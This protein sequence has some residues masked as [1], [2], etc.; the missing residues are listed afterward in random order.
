MLRDLR[1]C[2]LW[3]PLT[4]MQELRDNSGDRIWEAQRSELYGFVLKRVRDEAAA[5]DIVH[6][7]LVKAYERR[8]TL[9]E[10]GKLRPW[11]FQI[12]RNA[13]IDH[14]RAQRPAEALPED[15]IVED[16]EDGESTE[17]ELARCL[18]PLLDGLPEPY[19]DAL[20]LAEVEGS[21]QREVASRLGL[22][23]SGA[24]SRVQRGRRLLRSALFSCCSV[25]MDRRGGVMSYESRGECGGCHDRCK[26]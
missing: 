9:K 24:K 12:T 13:M 17:R 19:R 10:P 20:R 26:T 7:V 22:S 18:M 6:D 5:E 16:T 2:N 4:P 15:L 14:Y 21:P 8:E 3:L 25:E 23:L 1:T 11:L